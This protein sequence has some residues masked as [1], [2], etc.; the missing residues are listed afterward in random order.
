MFVIE[1]IM[2]GGLVNN[3]ITATELLKTTC[4]AKNLPMLPKFH[5]PSA[6]LYWYFRAN[7]SN[8]GLKGLSSTVETRNSRPVLYLCQDFR[9]MSVQKWKKFVVVC[10]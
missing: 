3:L 2:S 4:Q 5:W 10:Q 7:V 9:E 1:F 8:I 6:N